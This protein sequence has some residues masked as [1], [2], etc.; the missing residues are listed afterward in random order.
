MR[1]LAPDSHMCCIPSLF[2]STSIA[3]SASTLDRQ[4]F[5][6][7]TLPRFPVGSL[8]LAPPSKLLPDGGRLPR[9][10]TLCSR[11]RS[12][13]TQGV[14]R[15]GT[16]GLKYICFSG[17]FSSAAGQIED[18]SPYCEETC[19]VRGEDVAVA[20]KEKDKTIKGETLESL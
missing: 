15:N 1:M 20:K 9:C 14:R 4:A 8:S 12:P 10:V 19:D 5:K 2:V 16:Y 6:A 18:T 17:G 7:A 11:P 13:P 3:C